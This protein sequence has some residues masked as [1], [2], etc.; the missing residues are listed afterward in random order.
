MFVRHVC[1]DMYGYIIEIRFFYLISHVIYILYILLLLYINLC[2]ISLK[3]KDV[4]K[5][6]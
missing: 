5:Y 3:D 1:I 2:I 4:D 6:K